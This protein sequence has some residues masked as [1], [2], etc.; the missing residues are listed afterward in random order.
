[1]YLHE[2]SKTPD[3]PKSSHIAAK[4]DEKTAAAPLSNLFALSRNIARKQSVDSDTD[5]LHSNLTNRISSRR[6]NGLPAQ[7]QNGIENLSGYSM[8]S[9]RVHYNSPRPAQLQAL[10]YAKGEDIYVAPGQE[11]HLPHEAWHIVQQKQGRVVPTSR[12][13]GVDINND[14]SLE[15]EADVMGAKAVQLFAV[16][17]NTAVQLQRDIYP[18]IQLNPDSETKEF[19]VK[20]REDIHKEIMDLG[21]LIRI[22]AGFTSIKEYENVR[23][24]KAEDYKKIDE[25]WN[26]IVTA[27]FTYENV[28]KVI[29]KMFSATPPLDLSYRDTAS[30]QIERFN[31]SKNAD[32]RENVLAH[33]KKSIIDTLKDIFFWNVKLNFQSKVKDI[34]VTDSDLHTRG[35][36]VCI[37]T[38]YNGKMLV[39][40]PDQRSFEMVVYGKGNAEEPSLASVFNGITAAGAVGEL[41]INTSKFH[42][43]AIE[44][45]KHKQFVEIVVPG[46]SRDKEYKETLALNISSLNREAL[47][48]AREFI[49]EPTLAS[50][51]VFSSLLGLDDLHGENLVYGYDDGKAQLID[52]EAGIVHDMDPEMTSDKLLTTSAYKGRMMQELGELHMTDSIAKEVVPDLKKFYQKEYIDS[53]IGF[54]ENDVTKMLTDLRCRTVIF[55]TD[56]LYDWRGSIYDGKTSGK[57]V[58]SPKAY[59][60]ELKTKYKEEQLNNIQ[61]AYNSMISDFMKGI[62]PFYE[63]DLRTGDIYQIFSNGEVMIISD[64]KNSLRE[65]IDRN[66]KLLTT[67]KEKFRKETAKKVAAGAS[68]LAALGAL[69]AY[70]IMRKGK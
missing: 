70:A 36:G 39:I 44:Y 50:T 35:I 23:E 26:A 10:A 30:Y 5:K 60:N 2:R 43:S 21:N 53:L 9:V 63:R 64:P 55:G 20:S 18:V 57:P 69:V 31:K 15:H 40:K 34:D 16:D 19:K 11:K 33:A 6:N 27:F 54:L 13:N 52:S 67:M 51:I 48:K 32:I 1:M 37:V 45:F 41:E 65:F 68:I 56:Q 4:T 58:E 42:G 24:E 17:G 3:R 25:I 49:D 8:D 12:L 14:P 61:N 28:D 46:D 38:F 7:L 47:E 29:T 66:V 22:W 62:I 59:E